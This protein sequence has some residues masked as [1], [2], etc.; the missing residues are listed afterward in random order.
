MVTYKY[1]AVSHDGQTVSGIMEAFNELD[2]V[3][4]IKQTCD[5]ILKIAAVDED[6]TGFLNM[7]IGGNKLNAKAFT[8]MCSQ[9]AIILKAG[10]PVSRTVQLIADKTTD[11]PLKKMLTKV[12]EDVEAGRSLSAAFAERGEKILPP[13]FVETIRAGEESG[14][15]D[16]SFESMYQHFDKQVKMRA[17]VRSALAYPVFVLIIAVAVVIILMVKVVP[18]FTAIFEEFGAELP[19]ITR[20]LI[21]ISH[22][23]QRSWLILLVIAVVIAI[24]YKVYGNTEEG[25]IRFAQWGLK[26]PVLGNINELNAA[27]QFANSMAT[28][29]GAGLPLTKAVSITSKTLDNYFISLEVGKL[30]GKLEE[31]KALGASMREDQCLPDILVDMVGVG[32]E[33]GE[34]E[35]TLHTIAGY[36]DAE[37]QMATDAAMKKLEPALL[38]GLAGIAGFIVIAIYMAM[39]SMYSAM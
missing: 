33:T 15:I 24:A 2:A 3:D 32:E 28:M 27:S 10:I 23:F 14:N 37:L 12:A 9:F 5:I 18:T 6:N 26:L 39:F 30:T 13:T 11:K 22:F 36:Y 19:L 31:G 35:D 20:I 21:G 34:M 16:K 4:R 7:E 1:S 17:K 25:R 38:V 8:V 29:L